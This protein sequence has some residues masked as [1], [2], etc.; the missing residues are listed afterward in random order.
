MADSGTAAIDGYTGPGRRT[1]L[2]S[3]GVEEISFNFKKK[4]IG[5]TTR[6]GFGSYDLVQVKS[7]QVSSDGQEFI[8]SVTSKEPVN[9]EPRNSNETPDG[10]ATGGG[11]S[12]GYGGSE[13]TLGSTPAK[14]G[15]VPRK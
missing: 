2:L 4:I 10:S 3:N 7:I 6:D 12:E 15:E 5:V 14:A 8:L 13:K 9:V 1:L 11:K